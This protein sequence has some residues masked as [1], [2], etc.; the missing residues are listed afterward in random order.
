MHYVNK[1]K[2][3]DEWISESDF[4][5]TDTTEDDRGEI[6]IQPGTSMAG[7]RKR[8]RERTPSAAISISPDRE[9]MSPAAGP[10]LSVDEVVMT[11]EDFD[12]QHHKQITAQRNFDK[13]IFNQWQIKTW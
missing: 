8:K 10:S 4:R 11:E 5:L 13:V 6:E 3:L 2:R 7:T 9:N 12:I 1:D